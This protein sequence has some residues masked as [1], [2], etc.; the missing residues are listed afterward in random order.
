[1]GAPLERPAFTLPVA[2]L[3]RRQ[4]LSAVADRSEVFALPCV[5][6]N[7]RTIR[8][9]QLCEV[10]EDVVIDLF[11]LLHDVP[12]SKAALFLPVLYAMC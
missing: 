4:V 2:A 11:D 10:R 12:L 8:R 7:E 6:F 1:M 5:F 3:G 9:G